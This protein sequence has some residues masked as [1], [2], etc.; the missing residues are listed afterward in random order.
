[1]FA[2]RGYHAARVD[3]IVKAANTSHGT[4]YLYFKSKEDLFRALALEVAESMVELARDLPPLSPD[5]DSI[6]ALRAWLERFSALYLKYSAVVRS[7]TEAEIVESEMGTIG[8]D[9]VKQFSDELARRLRDAAPDV[10][11]G[12]AALAIVAMIERSHYYLVSQQ[13]QVEQAA[14]LDTL[15]RVTHACVYGAVTTP[16]LASQ[17]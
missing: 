7:W 1:M 12:T 9:L 14:L 6:V 13:V 17:V 11:A 15:A 5:G 2:D 8:G 4:F 10:D 16:E 3:D